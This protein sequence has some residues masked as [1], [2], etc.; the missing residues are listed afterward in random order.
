[1]PRDYRT[2]RSSPAEKGAD[3]GSRAQFRASRPPGSPVLSGSA[4]L[5]SLRDRL[6][7]PPSRPHGAGRSPRPARPALEDSPRS[8]RIAIGSLMEACRD[9]ARPG[10]H[11]T[12]G[13]P[14]RQ[15]MGQAESPAS[16]EDGWTVP[17]PSSRPLPPPAGGR[18]RGVAAGEQRHRHERRR[19]PVRRPCARHD[20]SDL[21]RIS[22]LDGRGDRTHRRPFSPRQPGFHRRFRVKRGISAA[23]PSPSLSPPS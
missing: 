3:P 2:A 9:F 15:R 8:R 11:S 19:R 12:L 6:R 21:V 1:M 20:P 16:G 7:R 23:C 18:K 14:G 13:G 17:P 10:P 4:S 5:P 22:Q